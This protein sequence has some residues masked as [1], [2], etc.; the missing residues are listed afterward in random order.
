MSEASPHRQL[1]QMITGYWTSQS[2]FA[3]A[4]LG[5]ADLL[6]EG[7]QHVNQLAA[8]SNTNSDALYR[9]LRALASIGI[10]AEEEQRRFSLTPLA[11]L[12]R[13]DIPGSK[14]ALAMM[15][16][17]EQFHAWAEILYTLETGKKSFDKVFNKPI[18]EYLSEHPDKGH[19]FD[20]AMTGI[21]GRE[22][23]TILEAYDFS[24]FK[25]LADIGGGNGSNLIGLLQHYPEMKGILFDLPHVVERSQTNLENAG[26]NN[27]C[28]S[29]GG[30]FFDSVPLTADAYLMRHIIH[31][32]DD[33]KSLTILR[34]CH[35]VM[36]EN[37]KL[38]VIESVIPPGNEPFAGKFLDLVMMLIPGGKE[39]TEEEYK[40]LYNQA[41]FEL[42]RIVPT[43]TELSII[44]GVKR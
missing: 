41:G 3:A 19:I 38:L 40:T 37:S 25:V 39:R 29:I 24:E 28:E 2:I 5:I 13:S 16:G 21:H 44:E 42:T 15:T 18:F 33:E 34:N 1:D 20:Q 9:L 23:S 7:P 35:A 4:K 12:L 27:R 14:R 36:P 6:E 30:S 26:L 31:D 8:A 17:D 11:E 10:F 43:K 32:W 22:T